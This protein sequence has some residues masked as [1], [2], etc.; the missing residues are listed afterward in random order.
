L[1]NGEDVSAALARATVAQRAAHQKLADLGMELTDARGRRLETG[2]MNIER[3]QLE[4]RVQ[5]YES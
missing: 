3:T 4:E 5:L 2:S 1:A